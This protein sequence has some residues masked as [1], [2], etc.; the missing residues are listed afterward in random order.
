MLST[1]DGNRGLW[2]AS[3]YSLMMMKMMKVTMALG[4]MKISK[5]GLGKMGG[6]EISLTKPSATSMVV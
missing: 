6:H 4:K 1:S 5:T 2:P 3:R